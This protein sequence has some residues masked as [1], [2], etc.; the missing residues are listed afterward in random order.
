MT[1]TGGNSYTGL[2]T[3]AAG[4]LQLGLAAQSA[5]LS[6]G[7]A[8]VRAGQ[9]LFNYAGGGDPAATING[10]LASSYRAAGGAFSAGQIFS[11]TVGEAG[12]A[13]GWT[14]DTASQTVIVKPAMF[15]DATLDGIVNFNDLA[16]V[17]AN[18]N[19]TG[20]WDGGDF[21]YDDTVNFNDLA[22]VLASYNQTIPAGFSVE[23]ANLDA[24]AIALLNGAGITTVP[25][26]G[27][28]IL[29]AAGL[30]GLLAYAWKRQNQWKRC[31]LQI[32]YKKAT[33]P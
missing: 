33:T 6:H 27:T 18:Y 17:L 28:L 22:L 11:S 16:L 32:I 9:L 15:G 8:D 3:V 5:V 23:G 2:T 12:L 14:D 29:L 4:T 10:L 21:T 24:P 30:L 7:G 20:T 13:L 1:L 25:E 19:G 26:P 31:P